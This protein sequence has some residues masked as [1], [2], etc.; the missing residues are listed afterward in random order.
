MKTITINGEKYDIPQS[1]EDITL[2][3]QIK[4]SKYID[5][6]DTEELQTIGMLGAYVDIPLDKLRKMKMT[7]V[8][9]L[10]KHV[11]FLNKPLPTDMISEFLFKNN[12]YYVGQ[13]LVDTEFQD[14]VSIQN[15][16]QKYSGNTIQALPLI[17]AIMAKRKK[18]NGVLETLD[19]YDIQQRAKMFEELPITIA[20][21]V[22]LFFYHS[23][24]VSQMVSHIYSNPKML[25]QVKINELKSMIQKQ[26]GVGLLMRWRNGILLW[27]LKYIEK[28][29]D[30]Y[31]TS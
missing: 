7:D 29:L 24:E 25:I 21:R 11:D 31:F 28:R 4:V 1:W 27:Y 15:A 26:G 16:M 19:D 8:N 2:G 20:H 3:K 22:S 18:E 5:D 23:I 17:I 13:N 12:T 9:R 30:K 10:S 6:F 14:F